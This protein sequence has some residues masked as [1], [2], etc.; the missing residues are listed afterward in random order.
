LVGCPVEFDNARACSGFIAVGYP[1]LR[2]LVALFIGFEIPQEVEAE[3]QK[4][5]TAD[6]LKRLMA[7]TR[8]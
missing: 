2:D 5:M 7:M 3:P 6:D 8:A 1:P 4:Y